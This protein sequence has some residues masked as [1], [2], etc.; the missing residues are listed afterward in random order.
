[1][2]VARRL[3]LALAGLGFFLSAP[4]WASAADTVRG[5]GVAARQHRDSVRSSA[6]R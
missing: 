1:M 5:S 4:P 3:F 6:S 2:S